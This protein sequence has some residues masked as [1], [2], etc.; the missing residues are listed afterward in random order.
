MIF[1]VNIPHVYPITPNKPIRDIL[2]GRRVVY[3]C[4]IT[5]LL[6]L[7]LVRNIFQLPWACLNRIIT[8]FFC[9]KVIRDMPSMYGLLRTALLGISCVLKCSE[10]SRDIFIHVFGLCKSQILWTEHKSNFEA[11]LQSDNSFDV[12]NDY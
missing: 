12:K 10:T 3:H 8:H 7:I 11:I 9:L 2:Q 5:H 4:L 1:T 6:R